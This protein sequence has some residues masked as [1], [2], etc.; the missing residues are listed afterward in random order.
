MQKY[1][2]IAFDL[3]N[4]IFDFDYLLALKKM[5]G[6][7]EAEPQDFLDEFFCRD[8]GIDFEKGLINPGDFFRKFKKRF[9]FSGGFG[10]FSEA[11]NSVFRLNKNTLKI[12][13]SLKDNYPLYLISNINEM[14]FNYLYKNYPEIFSLFK[15]LIL[16]FKVKSVKPERRIYEYL[17]DCSGEDFENII[18]IDD[19]LELIEKAKKIK[20]CCIRF[21]NSQDLIRRLKV[22]GLSYT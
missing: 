14:H 19:R 17:R 4:V 13:D 22:L 20:L 21:K 18:Y 3:G 1:K 10:E 2:A 8:F 12:I 6:K 11:W 9:K 15:K 5:A 7:A 16:S